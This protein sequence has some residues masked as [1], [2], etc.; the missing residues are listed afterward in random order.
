MMDDIILALFVI[1][2]KVLE[3][4]QKAVPSC[5]NWM[6]HSRRLQDMSWNF[7]TLAGHLSKLFTPTPEEMS[8]VA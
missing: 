7:M 6:L 2:E 1:E 5:I 3:N 4:H 8:V